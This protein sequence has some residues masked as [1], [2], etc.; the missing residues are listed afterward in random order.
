MRGSRQSRRES[1]TTNAPS[2]SATRSND[3]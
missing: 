2:S 3:M 1:S